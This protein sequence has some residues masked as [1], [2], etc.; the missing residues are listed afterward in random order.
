LM[1]ITEAVLERQPIQVGMKVKG[2]STENALYGT[3]ELPE[4][5]MVQF[6][7]CVGEWSSNVLKK[8]RDAPG[9]TGTER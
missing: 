1:A 4:L 6:Q 9:G 2:R 5:D 3:V 8:Y 7:Q